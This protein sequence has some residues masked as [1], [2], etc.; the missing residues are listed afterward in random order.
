MA[1]QLKIE[2]NKE[3][4]TLILFPEGELDIYHT[5]DFK[6]Q[7]LNA[8]NEENR[9]IIVDGSKLDYIDSTGLGGFIFLLNEVQKNN[10]QITMKN[11]KA[12]I[13]KL[14]TITKL[15]ELFIFEGEKNE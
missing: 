13:R 4:N 2:E 6:D 9:D 15:D 1:F 5:P 10:N 12:N 14:F 8:Y 11:I 3:E 7:A